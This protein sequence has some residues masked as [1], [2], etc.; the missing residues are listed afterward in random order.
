M[1]SPKDDICVMLANLEETY[2]RKVKE[3]R[4]K[5]SQVSMGVESTETIALQLKPR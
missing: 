4:G 2:N 3:I 1:R 5:R